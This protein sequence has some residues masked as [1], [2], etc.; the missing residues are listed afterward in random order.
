VQLG[1]RQPDGKTL[2]QHLLSAQSASGITPPMLI[3]EDLAPGGDELFELAI[4]LTESRPQGMGPASG[5]P[6]SEIVAWQQLHGVRLSPWH[7][8]T[9]RD[10]DRA[11]RAEAGRQAEAAHERRKKAASDE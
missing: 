5:I 6:P 11:M 4:E 2:R 7:V 3:D 10:I 8:T 9:L 1:A